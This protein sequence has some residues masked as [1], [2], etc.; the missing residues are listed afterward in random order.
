MVALA[1]L[2]FDLALP[3]EDPGATQ[4]AEPDRDETWVRRL[5]EKA[6]LGFARVELEPLGWRVRGSVHLD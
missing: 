2:A 6:V 4:L 5:F 1:E 3:T